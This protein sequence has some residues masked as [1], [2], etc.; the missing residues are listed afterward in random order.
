VREEKGVT[1]VSV[2]RDTND[3]NMIIMTHLFKGM[4]T[5]TGLANSEKGKTR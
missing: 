1:D 4:N 3:P 2:R 5:A